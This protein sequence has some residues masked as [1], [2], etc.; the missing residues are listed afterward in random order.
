M[1]FTVG[2]VLRD[3]LSSPGVDPIGQFD[4]QG[5]ALLPSFLPKREGTHQGRR[6][7]FSHIL[8]MSMVLITYGDRISLSRR[9]LD[10]EEMNCNI[11]IV[12][13]LWLKNH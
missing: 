4:T 7:R 13:Y 10:F 12:S 2:K 1:D 11:D 9:K 8:C 6:Q 5:R 3:P